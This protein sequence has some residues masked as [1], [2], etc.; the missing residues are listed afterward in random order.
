[1]SIV[2]FSCGRKTHP[3]HPNMRNITNGGRLDIVEADIV[4]KTWY[5]ESN[6]TPAKQVMIAIHNS[7]LV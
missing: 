1:M 5:H 4:T 7:K 6:L 2:S 3:F